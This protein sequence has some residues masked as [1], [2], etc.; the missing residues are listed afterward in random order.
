VDGFSSLTEE[1]LD[2]GLCTACGTCIGV[3][4]RDALEFDYHLEEP[5]RTADCGEHCRV[6]FGVCP[7]KDIPKPQ[8]DRLLFDRERDCVNEPVGIIKSYW[9]G[10]A[11]DAD[12]RLAGGSSGL[13]SALLVYALETKLVDAA[14]V[15]VMDETRPWRV[16]PAVV[17]TRDGVMAGG[18]TKVVV[19]PT[20]A[21]LAEVKKAGYQRIA[22][23]G[24]PC[25]VHGLRKSQL[26]NSPSWLANRLQFAIGLFCGA[27]FTYRATEHLIVEACGVPLSNVEK[28]EYRGG[29]YPGNV[30]VVTKSGEVVEVTSAERRL[31]F[32]GFLRDRC[33][34]CY[35]QT[36]EFA[37]VSIGD[38]FGSE[39]ARGAK[40]WSLMLVRTEI[41][42][43]LV[44]RAVK[45]GYI[46]VEPSAA[47]YVFGNVGFEWKMH[48]YGYH[49]LE[50][51]RH[52][53]PVPEY[54]YPVNADIRPRRVF[55][56]HPY[57]K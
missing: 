5:K 9:R 51:K 19:V 25:H 12:V 1:V 8:I 30:R 34:M 15:A 44:E 7:G 48:G 6:C 4:P 29:E 36:D 13:A 11:T 23:V 55:L 27:N 20:N 32:A 56:R 57:T 40:G 52:G 53:W 38:Y 21:A 16:K 45:D 10:Q 3:C 39:M 46:T 24:V 49:L 17:T 37:D 18:Q 54:H 47:E 41:G 35:D 33:A 26:L 2:S 42:G 50:R 31:F 43:R 22:I 28:L 14:V